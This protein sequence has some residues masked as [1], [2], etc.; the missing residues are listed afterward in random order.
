MGQ[1]W[2]SRVSGSFPS[3]TLILRLEL[4]PVCYYYI[5]FD[6]RF[7]FYSILFQKKSVEAQASGVNG[8]ATPESDDVSQACQSFTVEQEQKE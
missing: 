7:G 3:F 4:S 6:F 1:Y 2:E 8:S 5:E